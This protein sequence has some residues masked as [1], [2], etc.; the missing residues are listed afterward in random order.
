MKYS[1]QGYKKDSPDK[2][3]GSVLIPG[4]LI[5]MQN[6]DKQLTLIPIVNGKP[7]YDK[8]R[9]ANPG[10][11]DI[12]FGEGVTAVMEIPYAQA[13]YGMIGGNNPYSN[14]GMGSNVNF[15]NPTSPIDSSLEGLNYNGATPNMNLNLSGVLPP[16]NYIPQ[17]APPKVSQEPTEGRINQWNS[18]VNAFELGEDMK[19]STDPNLRQQME[20]QIISNKRATGKPFTGAINPYGG[21]NMAN[22]ST[23]LGA[24][25]ESGNTLGIIGSAGKLITEGARNAFSG[26]AA[27]RRYN[28]SQ[29]DYLENDAEARQRQDEYWAS[30]FQKG[31]TVDSK[32]RSGL[33]LTGNFLDGNEEHPMP[34]AEVESGEYLQTPDGN[35]M[36]I[37]GKRHSEGGELVSVPENTKVVSDYLKIGGKLATYFKKNYNL[38]VSAGSTFATVLDKYKKKIGLTKL[39]EDEAK[40]MEKIVDQEEVELESTRDINLQVLSKRV[41]D[42]Q[43]EKEPLEK[44]FNDF[45]NLIFEKQEESKPEEEKDFEKQ[46]GGQVDPQ[47]EQLMTAIQQYAEMNGQDPQELMSQIESMPPEQQEQILAEIMGGAQGQQQAGSSNIEQ[48]IQTYAQIVGQDPNAIIEQ[49]QNMSDEEVQQFIQEMTSTIE[50]QGGGETARAT[51]PDESTEGQREFKN[52]GSVPKYQ[53]AGSVNTSPFTQEDDVQEG[54]FTNPYKTTDNLTREEVKK[55]QQT[56]KDSGYDVGKSGIDGKLGKD[57]LRAMKEF[58]S[59]NPEEYKT[60]LS[61]DTENVTLYKSAPKASQVKVKESTNNYDDLSFGKAYSK[62]GAELGNNGVFTWRNKKYKIDNNI[63]GESVEKKTT[64]APKSNKK[65]EYNYDD[66][67]E[68]KLSKVKALSDEE[69]YNLDQVENKGYYYDMGEDVYREI[70]R[71]KPWMM[72]R[73]DAKY[74]NNKKLE[75]KRAEIQQKLPFRYSNNPLMY[76]FPKGQISQYQNGGSVPKYQPGGLRTKTLSEVYDTMP[77]TAVNAEGYADFDLQ[78][79]NPTTGVYDNFDPNQRIGRYLTD[80]PVGAENYFEQRPDGGY[81]LKKGVQYKDFQKGYNDLMGRTRKFFETQTEGMSDAQKKVYLGNLEKY[82]NDIIFTTDKESEYKGKTA[83]GIDNKFGQFTSTRSGYQ[84]NIVTPEQRKQLEAIGVYKLSQLVNNDDAKKIV[85]DELYNKLEKENKDFGGIDYR[86]L[87]KADPKSPEAPVPVEGGADINPYVDKTQQSVDLPMMTPDQSNLPP[88]YLATSMRQMGST[89]ADRVFLSPEENLKELARQSSTASSTLVNNNPYT[90]GAGLANLQAQQNNATNQAISQT[91]MANQQDQ[92]NV[93]NI[94]EERI[95]N[96]DKTNIGLAD[97]YEREQIVGL[98]NYYSEWRN[99]IDNRNKQNVVNWNL[100]NQ[101]NMFNAINPNYKIRSRGQIQQ[102]DEPFWIKL[103]GGQMGLMDP[104]T[105]QVIQKTT[106][107]DGRTTTVTKTGD[108]P[109]Q[110]RK[111]QKGGLMVTGSLLDLLNN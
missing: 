87:D 110:P 20:A 56:L 3:E 11:P 68:V 25:I 67:Y 26:A 31:G 6:V 35:T 22:T 77:F 104:K 61:F 12:D 70:R 80:V 88:K 102:T 9:I 106:I 99:F 52:G 1:I 51:V 30:S 101:Q 15:N 40:L 82:N 47:Q 76:N 71:R 46:E 92:R 53:E 63:N 93:S 23:M 95:M 64:A 109:R 66:E 27:M 39:L 24:S 55:L 107:P 18:Q 91:M 37:V 72:E 60:Q 16:A 100:Q 62:A 7:Q 78:H 49:M 19:V 4:N 50:S 14:M 94:N 29:Q 84:R 90:A 89:Q 75:K 17:G 43:P 83:R 58:Q 38:N 81:G 69:L 74:N 73:V 48:L 34:N 44:D 28:E 33:L 96:R 10:D 41:S 79:L 5:T 59:D 65:V 97:K 98:D 103:G 45:T 85:G 108:N 2:N 105:R 42:L 57:T 86:I 111:G 32:K 13:Q 36:E 21:W 8:R 54:D